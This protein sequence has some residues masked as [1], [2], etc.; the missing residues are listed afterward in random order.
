MRILV[1]DDEAAIR[2]VLDA[3]L[4]GW[5]HDV[6][7]AATGREAEQ[8]ATAFRPSV[9]ISDVVLPDRSGLELLASLRG[10]FTALP[11]IL[12]TAYGSIDSAVE[13]MKRGAVDFLTKPLDYNELRAILDQVSQDMRHQ[14]DADELEAA[15]SE[16]AGLGPL[17]GL[18][19]AQ[20]AIYDLIRTLADND[21]SVIIT[22]ESGT[23]K[24]LVARTI[25]QLGRRRKGPFVPVNAAAIPE[26][27]TEGQLLGHERGA[28]TGAINAQPG[29][30]E[31]AHTG[32]LFLDEIAEMP[33][34]LQ[35]KFLRVLEDGRVR[36]LGGKE[37]VSFDVR[38]ISAT[39]R[40]LDAA[41]ESGLMRADFYYRLN[42]FTVTVP[43]L[44]ERLEDL[45]LLAQH[46]MRQFNTKHGNAVRGLRPEAL[47]LLRSHRWPGNVRELAN[48]I[49]RAVIL[50]RAGWIEERH[51]PHSLQ[52]QGRVKDGPE[53]GPGEEGITLPVGVTSAKAEEILIRETLR[54]VGNNKA[55][56]ARRLGLDVKTIRNKLKQFGS[57][58]RA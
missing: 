34:S 4:R 44:R 8:Q 57:K 16:G 2:E 46:F 10:S 48:V 52:E 35:P 13:A 41:V 22:G 15:L 25:H 26:G 43:P 20:L 3:R 14:H 11:V 30:F 28:F 18:S 54:R 45:P 37:E 7:L 17:V 21:A 47:R 49:E 33:S 56:A 50:A 9:V 32:T 38:L 36:R 40:D 19:Q 58:A 5:G 12:I 1:V 51:L 55:A 42:V 27:L 23:G 29:F 24:E 6:C 39:N 31:L 53:A